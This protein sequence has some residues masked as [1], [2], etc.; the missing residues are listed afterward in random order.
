MNSILKKHLLFLAVGCFF[1]AVIHFSGIGCPFLWAFHIPCPTC[2]VTRATVSL[3]TGDVGGYL[4][5]QPF[6]VPLIAAVLLLLHLKLFKKGR[7]FV[8]ALSIGIC[9]LNFAYYLY[10]LSGIL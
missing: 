7:A 2:G 4:S 9:V 6:A 10:R 1:A 3:L 8:M 5:H